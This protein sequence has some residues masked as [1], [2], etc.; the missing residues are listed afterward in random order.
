VDTLLDNL[1]INRVTG[2]VEAYAYENHEDFLHERRVLV[3]Q[4]IESYYHRR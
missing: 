2:D 1:A 3:A 4:K